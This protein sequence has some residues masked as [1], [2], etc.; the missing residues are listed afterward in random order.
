MMHKEEKTTD[1]IQA[2]D[3][4]YT[5]N[6]IQMY[7]LLLPYFQ[8]QMQKKLAI[9][10]K[11]SELQYTL[12]YFHTHPYACQP[13]QPVPDTECLCKELFPYCTPDEKNKLDKL[14]QYSSTMKNAKEMM[15]TME[16]MKEMCPDGMPFGKGSDDMPDIAQILS[17]LNNQ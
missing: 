11:L 9:Y 2:F 16:M 10:I 8:P 7:K 14:I 17:M 6:H 3:S 13:K 1:K 5:T 15:E 12:S 4:I